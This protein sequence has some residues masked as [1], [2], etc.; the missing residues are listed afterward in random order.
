MAR[1]PDFNRDYSRDY[2]RQDY[3]RQDFN[4]D[5]ARPDFD[6]DY[7]H[8]DF[9]RDY[10]RQDFNRDYSRPDSSRN[11]SEEAIRGSWESSYQ[12]STAATPRD[13]N[14]SWR[15]AM[16]ADYD[17][18]PGMV[19]NWLGQQR[20]QDPSRVMDAVSDF[21]TP[22]SSPAISDGSATFQTRPAYGRRAPDRTPVAP[23][24]Y[25]TSSP[26]RTWKQSPDHG[27]SSRRAPSHSAEYDL[28]GVGSFADGG[29]HSRR[30]VKYKPL[31]NWFD[32]WL[33]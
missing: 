6:R 13:R 8:Q 10:P 3:S 25:Y 11:W 5:Y 22:E 29:D 17:T 23:P 16:P 28:R 14:S 18:R 20:T 12:R 26:S 30:K 7:S 27:S 33:P 4:R 1:Q 9:N 15:G 21:A 2:S 24:E 32:M 19:D 31:S